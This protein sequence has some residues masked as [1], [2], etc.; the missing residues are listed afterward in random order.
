MR[1][2]NSEQPTVG[3]GGGAPA[4]RASRE[5][6][7]RPLHAATL[8]SPPPPRPAFDDT[9]LTGA[10]TG[11]GG[12]QGPTSPVGALDSGT[13]SHL[14]RAGSGPPGPTAPA[15]QEAGK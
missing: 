2:F 11:L 7:E 1:E 14:P 10:R 9:Q 3:V 6:Q 8:E 5:Q 13:V 4:V 15:G 12:P